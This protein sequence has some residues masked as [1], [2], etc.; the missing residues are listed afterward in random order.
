MKRINYVITVILAMALFVSCGKES[1]EPEENFVDNL[2]LAEEAEEQNEY[3]KDEEEEIEKKMEKVGAQDEQPESP[4]EVDNSRWEWFIEPGK[5]SDIVLYDENFIAVADSSGKYG[6]LDGDKNLIVEHQYTHVAGVSE[7]IAR[8]T[9]QDYNYLFLDYNGKLIT[10]E[11]FPDANDFSEG[12]AAVEKEGGW[13]F[14]NT[15]GKIAI[16][17]QYDHV[18]EFH[19]GLAAV[20]TDEK[21][22]YIDKTGKTVFEGEYEDVLYFSEGMAAVQKEGKWGFIDKNGSLRID[23]QYEDAG[24]FREGKAAVAKTMDGYQEW[25]YINEDNEVVVDYWLCSAAE[26]RMELAGEFHDGYALITSDLYCL[27]D[28][29]GKTVLG[30]NNPFFLTGGSEYS[31]EPG[32]MAAYDYTDDSMTEEKYGFVDINGRIKVPF[33]F[34][35]V[36]EIHGDLAA[37]RYERGG[38]TEAGVIRLKLR[39]YDSHREFP[40]GSMEYVD[41]KNYAF[42]KKTYDEIDFTGEYQMGNQEL[43]EEYRKEYKKL[44]DNEITFTEPET[45]E[46]YYLK[47]YGGLKVYKG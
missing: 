24:N 26:G 19:E 30:K 15:S 14:I 25:A 21:W 6:F 27:I 13:G 5:Y 36:S 31:I 45:G 1:K 39:S 20:E 12:L 38:K 8:V 23:F 3:Q 47:E 43:Y 41:E 2:N 17:C 34:E 46:T 44:V 28:E 16:A 18:T 33:I 4:K 37:V 29:A 9:D 35:H 22:H 42:L 11:S 7:Q 10:E 32:W 40:Y